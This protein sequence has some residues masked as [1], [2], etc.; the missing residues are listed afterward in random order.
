M[1][2][3]VTRTVLT[4][5]IDGFSTHALSIITEQVFKSVIA[6]IIVYLA[7]IFAFFKIAFALRD[8]GDLK[9][10]GFTLLAWLL[11]MPIQ[12][13]PAG[14]HLVDSLSKST[15]WVLE[16]AADRV[17]NSD[18]PPG[19]IANSIIRAS[20][21]KIND[22]NVTRLIEGVMA[23]VPD[24]S[25][26][27]KNKNGELLTALDLLI[28]I[29][30]VPHSNAEFNIPNSVIQILNGRDSPLIDG[31]R[32]VKCFDLMCQTQH[33]IRD[34]LSKNDLW[35]MPDINNPH[36]PFSPVAVKTTDLAL[37]VAHGHAVRAK[38]AEK[39]DATA[40]KTLSMLNA[41]THASAF[42]QQLAPNI[43]RLLNI[44]YSWNN[45]SALSEI[46][47]KMRNLPYYI[48]SIKIILKVIA[49]LAFLALLTNSFNV[50]FVWISM[51]LTA[52]LYP[53]IASFCRGLTNLILISLHQIDGIARNHSELE[54]S[55]DLVNFIDLSAIDSMLADTPNFLNSMLNA[56]L[57]LYGILGGV[58][59]AGSWF[60]GRLA[61]NISTKL[62]GFIGSIVMTRTLG[63]A[64][65]GMAK[66]LIGS[67][68]GANGAND[69]NGSE[70][71]EGQFEPPQNR[72]NAT[73]PINS[74]TFTNKNDEK[75][76]TDSGPL[77]GANQNFGKG[78]TKDL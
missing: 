45:A 1:P 7:I 3:V 46:E 30:Y 58:M 49:P 59:L 68:S 52:S 35:H 16:T 69:A 40:G 12:G 18:L 54:D 24:S 2:S 56:E 50:T 4:D 51:W 21:V 53:V 57:T 15:T 31:S 65:A 62:A 43:S 78:K 28:P 71:S 60:S 73:G 61:N 17:L 8:G 27:I 23:C 77:N 9:S 25:Q 44:E 38:A 41:S 74:I 29:K 13:M 6:Q 10:P 5:F 47:Q 75:N 72:S 34:H 55:S 22:P 11:C 26:R 64:G 33:A 42:I 39:L 19:F 32:A 36:N 20:N 14:L 66:G 70:S 63:L 48:S 67:S 76:N 37:N